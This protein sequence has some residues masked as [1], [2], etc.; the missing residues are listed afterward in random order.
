MDL[1]DRQ[2]QVFR[3]LL[4]GQSAKQIAAKLGIKASTVNATKFNIKLRLGIHNNMDLLRW[5]DKNLK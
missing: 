3:G 4:K 5:G 1:T 2:I